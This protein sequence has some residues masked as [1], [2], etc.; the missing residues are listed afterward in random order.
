MIPTNTPIAGGENYASYQSYLA[1]VHESSQQ[2]PQTHPFLWLL[3]FHC[4]CLESTLSSFLFPNPIRVPTILPTVQNR[5]ISIIIPHKVFQK[6]PVLF[7]HSPDICWI[8]EQGK[9]WMDSQQTQTWGHRTKG[10]FGVGLAGSTRGTWNLYLNLGGKQEC[11][12]YKH[13]LN[14]TLNDL[15]PL[16]RLY[17]H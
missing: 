12:F 11:S 17:S 1:T 10:N 2:I 15:Y 9:R 3:N 7:Y 4:F 8:K 5:K 14:C 6:V 13:S 16:Y